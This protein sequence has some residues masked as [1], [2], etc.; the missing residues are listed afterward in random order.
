M[1]VVDRVHE[2]GS[3]PDTLN[4]FIH[5]RKINVQ[6]FAD[7]LATS[8]V[9][10]D[11]DSTSYASPYY[12]SLA[13]IDS[14]LVTIKKQ[15]ENYLVSGEL[16]GRIWYDSSAYYFHGQYSN[17]GEN[18]CDFY[19]D[20]VILVYAGTS[21]EATDLESGIFRSSDGDTVHFHLP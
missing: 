16:T 9:T 1:H 8:G 7:Q 20:R 3:V 5:T 6:D 14:S 19:L 21:F 17:D 15:S 4:L 12:A 13:R 11:I 18:T 10:F 2:P